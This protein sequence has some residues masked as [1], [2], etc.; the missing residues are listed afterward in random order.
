MKRALPEFAAIPVNSVSLE[1]AVAE[2]APTLFPVFEKSPLALHISHA[3]GAFSH[4]VVSR[5]LSSRVWADIWIR[6]YERIDLVI[7]PAPRYSSYEVHEKSVEILDQAFASVYSDI[8]HV[9]GLQEYRELLTPNTY[10]SLSLMHALTRL[11]LH[12]PPVESL[13]SIPTPTLRLRALRLIDDFVPLHIAHLMLP[14]ISHWQGRGG[15]NR[16]RMLRVATLLDHQG[17]APEEIV[18]LLTRYSYLKVYEYLDRVGIA[19]EYL[20]AAGD[21]D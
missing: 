18:R 19:D 15:G 1:D 10:S 8:Y 9:L 21:D 6:D 3:S 20:D 11:Y 17:V 12:R 14:V 7:P 13:E 5:N 16:E 2:S 4:N